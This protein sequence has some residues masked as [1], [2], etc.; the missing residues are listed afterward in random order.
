MSAGV[1][2]AHHVLGG[3]SNSYPTEVL[4]DAPALYWKFDETSGTVAVDSSGNA[5]NGTHAGSPL[6]GQASFLGDGSGASARW[7]T[8]Q[9]TTLSPVAWMFSDWTIEAVVDG[10]SNGYIIDKWGSAFAARHFLLVFN[11][12]GI[13]TA[14]RVAG[15]QQNLNYAF[16]PVAGRKYTVTYTRRSSD[17]LTSIYLDGVPAASS[18]TAGALST[19]FTPLEVNRVTGSSTTGPVMVDELSITLTALSATRIAARHAARIAT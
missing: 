14:T 16:T 11:A 18:T 13:T 4:A 8:N 10:S 2:A 19:D 3:T 5:R 17:G 9:Y 15:V 12:S 1:I 7:N 6:L